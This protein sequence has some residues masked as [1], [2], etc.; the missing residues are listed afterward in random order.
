M[1]QLL[2]II[3]DVYVVN[4]NKIKVINLTNYLVF[5]EYLLQTKEITL[6]FL[7]IRYNKVS[8]F[9]MLLSSTMSWSHELLLFVKT[10][11]LKA[12][13]HLFN[14]WRQEFE[15]HVTQ[16]CNLTSD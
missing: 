6:H 14:I 9:E 1:V 15:K 7:A 11:L 4:I 8:F 13:F 2:K 3:K 5:Y 16:S 10:M 12:V